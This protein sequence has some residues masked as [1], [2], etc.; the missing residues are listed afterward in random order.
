MS[1]ADQSLLEGK[2][3]TFKHH[4][5]VTLPTRENFDHLK[6]VL[7]NQEAKVLVNGVVHFY[8]DNQSNVVELERGMTITFFQQ[9]SAVLQT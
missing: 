9:S 3:V 1:D 7:L 4:T 8:S 6:L 5:N 2:Q